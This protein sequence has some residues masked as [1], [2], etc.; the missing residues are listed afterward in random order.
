MPPLLRGP[1]WLCVALLPALGAPMETE[2]V[3]PIRLDPD[4][5]GRQYFQRGAEDPPQPGAVFQ[6]TAFREDFYLNL[7]P[8]A[9]FLAPA[10]ATQ[11]LGAPRRAAQ[12][13]LRRCFYSGDVN[14][15]R[16]SFAAL[17]LCGGLT[18]AFGYRG[19]EYLISPFRNESGGAGRA[20]RNDQGAHLLQRRSA[21]RH[22]AATSRC[23][24]D[25]ASSPALV[26]ALE[27]YRGSAA[28][29]GGGQNETGRLLPAPA[30]KSSRAKRFVSLPRYVETLV[31]ADES[32]VKF[33]G[34]DLQ[35]YLLTLM[36]T[37]ARL[38]RHPSIQNPINLAVVKFV[39]IGRDEK[40]PKVTG[41]A[42]L[43]LRN[44]CVWQKKW[45]KGSDKHPEY[46]DTAIL[47]T[48][49]DLCGAT[50]C[51]TL[52][53]ADVGTMCDPKRS[54]SVIE[55]DGLP[56]AFTTAHELGHVFNMPHDNVKA[57]EEVFGKL[58][59]NHMMSPTLIQI[60]RINPW[61]PCS[62]AII[63]DF[64]DSG[65]GDC[66]LDQP[67]KPIP[68]P[69]DL[70]GSSYNLNQQCELAFGIGSKPCPYMQYCTKLWCTGKARG[71]IMCQT[72][73][74]PWA[75]GTSCGEGRFC[76]KGACVERHNISKYQVDGSWGKWAPYGQCSRTCGGGVQLAK[77]QC[78][79]PPPANEGKYCEG[80]RVKYR[81]C[82][83]DPC[84]DS[85]PGKS[86]REEQCEAF[87]GYNHSTNR[88]TAIVS[89]VPKYSGVSPRDK[90]KLICR[91][92]GTGYFYVLAPKVVDGTP[93]SPD[94]S[95]LCVQGKC[96]KAGC[97]GKLG[98]K[99][100]FDKCGV[101]GGDNK[102]CK[103]VS[104]LFTKPMHGY[105]FVVL[106]PA[107][108]SSIDIRQ[109]GYKGLIS[110]DNY[111]ALKNGHGKY[112]LNGHFIVSAVERDLI[113]KGSVMRYSGTGTA[114]ESLQAF[115]PIQE[116][117]T[118]EV[119]SVGKMTPPRVR[120]SFYLSKESKEDK[121]SY[122]KDGKR[123][124]VLNNSILSLSN[125]LD[126]GQPDYKRPSYKWATTS[127]EDC[128]V[129]CGN[130]LQKRMVLCRD[131]LGQL[132]SSCDATQRPVDIRICGDPCPTW[133]ASPW[134]SCSKTCGRGFKRRI[135]RCTGRGGTL[136]PRERCNLRK[137]PQELDFCTLR[138]C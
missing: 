24:V 15:D 2:V 12:E 106:L 66:L 55:D 116:P 38:Y 32:M 81:S 21:P 19:A 13:D 63:T 127:W 58:K 114:V 33:H 72:R 53:M 119:L 110:D 16:D 111:L 95:S 57:C 49:Q 128:S 36:A 71:H 120:Y 11:Y 27:K 3:T 42:A 26:Q 23:G 107:G 97:D 118:V 88:L 79:N 39:V 8:D 62:T 44:F 112:L 30:R 123:P 102:S 18:G 31:V 69:Q 50:T 45:N 64:L 40:G 103:K 134:S 126:L 61:S 17:S 117:L 138:P 89:W 59:T 75:D 65:H 122:R 54:C 78:N 4:L 121:S 96:I 37:A 67:T 105:N 115:M 133:E 5:N 35:H 76:L 82:G 93:C 48:K 47:F 87:N 43:T 14:S 1:F 101:C 104:G 25:S 125:R 136:L 73:H 113:V 130:G 68:L 100:K 80:V 74:F 92:N 20:L 9:Q 132:A 46:W 70:P 7:T 60:D 84:S 56:S 129:T 52:G 124:P 77:R 109:R 51:D 98:S 6:I 85:V 131:T 83:L 135:L 94:S 29:G 41:N 86:F 91:A 22:A 108:A 28:G 34:D 90:C 137:K 10:F 99:K